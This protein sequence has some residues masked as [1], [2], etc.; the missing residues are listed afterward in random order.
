MNANMVA[1]V[2]PQV[3]LVEASRGEDLDQIRSALDDGAVV[4]FQV[5]QNCLGDGPNPPGALRVLIEGGADVV[6]TTN[7]SGTTAL[8]AAM[9]YGHAMP[10]GENSSGIRLQTDCVRMLLDAGA[11]PNAVNRG[12][13]TPMHCGLDAQADHGNSLPALELLVQ[14]GADILARD[15]DDQTV[16]TWHLSHR[17]RLT[18]VKFWKHRAAFISCFLRL[19]CNQVVRQEGDN[20]FHAIFTAEA[21]SFEDDEYDDYGCNVELPLGRLESS[22]DLYVLFA[23]VAAKHPSALRA[24]DQ[25]GMSP[26]AVACSMNAPVFIIEFL[27]SS[28]PTALQDIVEGN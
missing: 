25:N 5:L 27:L 12:G 22:K 18:D 16:F 21:T 17:R 1:D 26:L 20:S 19:Y 4:T 15:S 28:D 10:P 11:N 3:R 9:T 24:L 23:L 7:D 2:P 14:G 8:H 6:G 13:W